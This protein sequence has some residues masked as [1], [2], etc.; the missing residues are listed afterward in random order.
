MCAYCVSLSPNSICRIGMM[1]ANEKSVK[2]AVRRL[3]SML[4]AMSRL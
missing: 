3:K 1:N 4:S 2:N